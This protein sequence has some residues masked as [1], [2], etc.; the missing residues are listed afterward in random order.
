MAAKESALGSLVYDAL[1][2]TQKSELKNERQKALLE[3]QNNVQN[4][5]KS[6]SSYRAK[7]AAGGAGGISGGVEAGLEQQ[8][9]DKNALVAQSFNQK[10]K[11]N[12]NQIRKK[13]LL[14]M[15]FNIGAD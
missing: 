1:T 15:G 10:A 13:T 5:K 11:Q 8:L 4:Y 2:G 6:L 12:K 14:S 3:Q 7:M 9:D